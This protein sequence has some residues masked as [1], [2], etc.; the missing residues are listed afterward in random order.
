MIRF[1]WRDSARRNQK[2]VMALPLEQFLRR[3]FLHVLP[4]GFVRIRHFGLFSNRLRTVSIETCRT[5]L[6]EAGAPLIRSFSP[7]PILRRKPPRARFKRHKR[8]RACRERERFPSSGCI[9]SDPAPTLSSW[10]NCIR[11]IAFDTALTLHI[12]DAV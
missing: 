10:P 4:P 8:P 1:R 9:E 3:F 12:P 11:R 5:L 7:Q 6:A 2:R